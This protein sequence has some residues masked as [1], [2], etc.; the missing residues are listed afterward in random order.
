M[1][2]KYVMLWIVFDDLLLHFK[3]GVYYRC[4]MVQMRFVVI[5][6][7][8]SKNRNGLECPLFRPRH[9]WQY[10]SY[11]L[12]SKLL[13]RCIAVDRSILT[14]INSKF[15]SF[16]WWFNSKLF[17]AMSPNYSNKV[18]K[19]SHLKS[20]FIAYDP[21]PLLGHSAGY[22]PNTQRKWKR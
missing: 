20:L 15:L 19:G 11:E 12:Y 9:G 7:V 1:P 4:S 18:E 13:Y 8:P 5:F 6:K 3:L 16:I 14:F 17:S 10:W 2:L 22:L 21:P